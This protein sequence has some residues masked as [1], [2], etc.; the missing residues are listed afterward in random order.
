[1]GK[2]LDRGIEEE[3]CASRRH[4]RLHV[5]SLLNSKN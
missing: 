3:E 1:M 2:D 5:R 4:L